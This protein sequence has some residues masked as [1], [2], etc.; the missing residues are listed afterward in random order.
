MLTK[1]TSNTILSNFS[2]LLKLHKV[3]LESIFIKDILLSVLC[4]C[5]EFEKGEE[6]GIKANQEGIKKNAKECRKHQ[7]KKGHKIFNFFC[8]NKRI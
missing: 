2:H 5:V 3:T 1:I 8:M 6:G 7:K 4:V